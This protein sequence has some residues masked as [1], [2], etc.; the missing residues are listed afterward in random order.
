MLLHVPGCRFVQPVTE[1]LL[2]P[3]KMVLPPPGEAVDF[4]VELKGLLNSIMANYG[5]FMEML[6]R[7]LL[8]EHD[9]FMMIYHVRVL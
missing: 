4:R 9:C 1:E 8:F 3:E 7:Y 5:Q 2:P 6:V